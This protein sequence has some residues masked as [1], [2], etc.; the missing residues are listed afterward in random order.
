MGVGH[1]EVGV[2][3]STED[4]VAQALGAVLRDHGWEVARSARRL[5][6]TLNDVLGAEAED[7]RARVDALV[8]AVEESVVRDLLVAGRDRAAASAP[9]LTARLTEWGLHGAIAAWA[10]RTWAD[11]LP[12]ATIPPPATIPPGIIPPTTPP[13]QEPTTLPPAGTAPNDGV[14]LA[15]AR[16]PGPAAGPA[17]DRTV[18]PRPAHVA[19]PVGPGARRRRPSGRVLALTGAVAVLAAGGI[20]TAVALGDGEAADDGRADRAASSGPSGASSAGPSS[21]PADAGSVIPA[22]GARVPVT[23]GDLAMAARRGGVR[24]SRL[25]E[26]DSVASGDAT[27]SAPDGGTLLGFRLAGWACG[28]E[29]CRPWDRLELEVDVD[30]T[31]SPLPEPRSNNTFAVAVPAGA[32]TVDLVLKADGLT[33][34]LSLLDAKP[35]ADNIAVLAR[36]GRV[37]RVGERFTVTETNDTPIEFSDA[38]T[39]TVPRSVTVSKAEL[40]WFVRGE[41][42]SSTDRAFLKV[43]VTYTIPYGVDAGEPFGFYP[44]EIG[45]VGAD[46][47]TYRA[48]DLDPG[49]GVDAVFE[50]PAMLRGG[51]FVVGGGRY[52]AVSETGPD[53]RSLSRGTAKLSFE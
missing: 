39:R 24:V 32:S 31:R 46:G 7:H 48:R 10:V 51:T 3:G 21:A 18:A 44:W 19:P 47:T 52:P 25:G 36:R 41:R 9:V 40:T 45:F 33:Q 23:T 38:V 5:R 11:Q 28:G 20:A 8:I 53:T 26:V 17:L 27:L 12:G 13:G 34:T 29:A 22:T 37:D 42:P 49:P 16:P 4:S 2:T 6:G 15:P 30:G 1:K 43:G 35:G 14:T 50:V